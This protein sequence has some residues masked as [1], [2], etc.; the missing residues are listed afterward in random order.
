MKVY[1]HRPYTKLPMDEN[2]YYTLYYNGKQIK[3]YCINDNT[4]Q[5][6]ELEHIQALLDQG[7]IV[8]HIDPYDTS[9][10]QYRLVNL[11]SLAYSKDEDAEALLRELAQ[12]KLIG[13]RQNVA[14]YY[15][16]V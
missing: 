15:K 16:E 14:L 5:V 1:M 4:V 11:K 7:F 3:F 10:T 6:E 8:T 12:W 13:V 2:R 9:G